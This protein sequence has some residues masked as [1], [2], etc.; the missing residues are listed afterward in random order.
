MAH[1][2][3]VERMTT[4]PAATAATT[5]IPVVTDS[6]FL[7]LDV[8]EL[9]VPVP[10]LVKPVF[11]DPLGAEASR[12]RAVDEL[13]LLDTPPEDRFDRVTQLAQRLFGV[14]IAKNSYRG[15][16]EGKFFPVQ[17]DRSDRA[18]GRASRD[19][20]RACPSRLPP[21]DAGDRPHARAG[22]SRRHD[23]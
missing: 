10:I 17:A 2:A 14:Q 16:G 20:D 7:D 1:R 15:Q 21:G 8:P 22:P 13:G 3:A 9:A 5:E 19:F 23:Q 11:V 6:D 12:Q 18:E 4:G